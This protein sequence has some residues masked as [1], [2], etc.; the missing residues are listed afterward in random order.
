MR[1]TQRWP[2]YAAGFL[3]AAGA[4]SVAAGVGAESGSL[5]LRILTVGI[6]LA[7]YDVAEVVLKPLF[8]ALSDRVGIRRVIVAGLVGFAL[9]SLLGTLL[10]GPLAL[11]LVRLGQGASAAAF[12]PASSAAV[13][14]LSP[15]GT[16]GRFFGRYGSWKSL[17]YALGPLA[18]AGLLAWGGFPALLLAL[19]V[20]AAAIA[21]WV[22]IA[23]PVIEVLPRPRATL[24]DLARQLGS[25][26]FLLPVAALAVTT[27]SLGVAVGFLPLT[28]VRSQLGVLPGM[29]AVTVLAVVSS[30]VQPLVGRRHDHGRLAARAGIAGGLALVA[31]GVVALAVASG[32]TGATSAALLLAA[33]LLLGAGIGVVTPLGFTVLVGVTPPERMGRTMGAAELGR[34]LGDAGGPLLVGAVATAVGIGGGLGALAA[35]VAGTGILVAVLLGH[36][37]QDA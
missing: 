20:A 23:V 33:A 12:S 25:R 34:E 36:A 37:R 6:L 3:S 31:L 35:V 11:A 28:A 32:L 30:V 29:L 10:S 2:L 9:V 13:A 1:D 19:A 5:G 16:V 17:G 21:A 8:G 26:R 27:G 7:L 15:S 18:G 14:R 24:L 4:H 22:A